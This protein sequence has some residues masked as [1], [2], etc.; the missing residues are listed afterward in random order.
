LSD[1]DFSSDNSSIL[2]EDENVKRKHGDFTGLCL[3]GKSLRNIFDSDSDVSEDLS[4]ESLSLK[5]IELEN[6]LCNQDK[7]IWRVFHENKKLN[8]ELENSF[9][10]IT[11][12]RLMH[13]DISVKSCDNYKMIM[14]NYTDLWIVHSQVASQLKGAKLELQELK[15]HSILLVACTSCPLLRSDLEAS[16]IE[17]KDL[18]HQFDYYSRYSILSP[19][20][21]MCG[22]LKGMLFYATKQNTEIK[23]EFAYLTS[24]LER[25][26]V[27]EKII[28]DDLS[29][30]EESVTKST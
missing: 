12:L 5:I 17:I 13:D 28:E 20:C 30:I 25:T 29:R 11:S 22:C 18:K 4:F 8:L 15:S 7:L 3:M 2:E 16:A 23:Q 21:E 6:V 27:S 19:P 14:V 10:E 24:H 9:S 26:I 1:F